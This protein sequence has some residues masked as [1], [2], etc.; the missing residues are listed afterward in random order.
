MKHSVSNF[1]PAINSFSPQGTSSPRVGRKGGA[2]DISV[3][4]KIGSPASP[5][6]ASTTSFGRSKLERS[7]GA[8]G[9]GDD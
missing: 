7:S 8:G 5:G 4:N 3:G 1:K 9:M 6:V 2:I